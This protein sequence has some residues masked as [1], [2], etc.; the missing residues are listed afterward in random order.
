[1]NPLSALSPSRTLVV[2]SLKVNV[3]ARI[4]DLAAAA[5]QAAS[6]YLHEILAVQSKA[7]VILASAA[8]QVKFLEQ[9][10]NLGGVDWSRVI[11]F[12]MDEY[13]GISPEH[14][15]SFRRFMRERVAAKLK[16][17]AFH[18]LEGDA[19]QPMDECDRYTRLLRAQSIDL[20][21]LGI[22]ENGHVA[23]NDPAVADFGDP[24]WVKI[25]KLDL[26]CRQQQ[27]GEG[28]F[29]HLPAVP[30][31][32]LTLTVPTLFSAKKVIAIV[33]E[34][35]KAKAVQETLQ[36]PVNSSCPASI[37]RRQPHATL[38]L[39]EDSASLL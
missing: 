26:K 37:L 34:K 23:F 29:P 18:Y 20:C 28:A 15:A 27:V 24:R 30:Q 36:A 16:P 19:L 10:V 33:P 32:A 7:A 21:C 8:S 13:L 25:V 6:S 1:M 12:H 31:Y 9:L 5:A 4:E 35:R 38:Y 14:A 2:D 17:L 22:G 11:L 3:Y 39:D